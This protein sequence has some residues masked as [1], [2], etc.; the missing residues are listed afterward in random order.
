[1]S[2]HVVW[3]HIQQQTHPAGGKRR[4]ELIKT[5]LA[6]EGWI[7]LI[8]RANVI[9]VGAF[10]AGSKDRRGIAIRN[11]Q[12]AQIIENAGGL[13]KSEIAVELKAIRGYDAMRAS[14]RK[15]SGICNLIRCCSL[16]QG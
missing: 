9:A 1:M 6:A 7:H 8:K 14:V 3:D 4:S 16:G 10:G 15:T 11:A 13:G 2:P 5:L 12:I